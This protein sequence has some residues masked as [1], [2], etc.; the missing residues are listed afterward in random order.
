MYSLPLLIVICFYVFTNLI[1]FKL[2]I[3]GVYWINTG[4]KMGLGYKQRDVGS[5]TLLG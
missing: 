3:K 2:L 1:S 5:E 4:L